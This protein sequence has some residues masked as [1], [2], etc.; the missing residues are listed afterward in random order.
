MGSLSV[1]DNDAKF[2]ADIGRRAHIRLLDDKA[3]SLS[4]TGQYKEQIGKW[5]D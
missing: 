4:R 2:E 3:E 5:S 1:R